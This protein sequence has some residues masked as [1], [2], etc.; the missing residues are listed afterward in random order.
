MGVIMATASNLRL[1]LVHRM[2]EEP[3][4]KVCKAIEAQH[5]PHDASLHHEAWMQLF[6]IRKKPMETYVDPYRRVEV[7]WGK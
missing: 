4:W 3:V 5:Q 6:A 7:P 2:C 1:E